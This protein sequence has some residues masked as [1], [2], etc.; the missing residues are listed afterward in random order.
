M[1]MKNSKENIINETI[2]SID[3]ISRAELSP[4][5]KTRVNAALDKVNDSF[6]ISFYKTIAVAAVSFILLLVN[7]FFISKELNTTEEKVTNEISSYK[8]YTNSNSINLT[9]IYYY[10]DKQ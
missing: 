7:V 1:I 4:F 3:N 5:F 6:G 10:D 2:A 9:S 8:D